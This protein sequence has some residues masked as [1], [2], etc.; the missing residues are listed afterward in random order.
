VR[1]GL[2]SRAQHVGLVIDAAR[3]NRIELRRAADQ[4]RGDVGESRC[5][6]FG[7]AQV[8]GLELNRSASQGGVVANQAR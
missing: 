4:V 8:V 6:G 5:D 1:E 3:A 2:R 7:S